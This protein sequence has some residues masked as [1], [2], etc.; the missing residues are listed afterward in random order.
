MQFF[1]DISN[2]SNVSDYL[3]ILN[4]CINTEI[5]SLLLLDFGIVQSR[6]LN[7]WY[8]KY[9]LIASLVDTLILFIIIIITR[10]LYKYLFTGF[11]I[12]NF[13]GLAIVVQ[14]IHD[15][16]FYTFV[17]KVRGKELNTF[18][19]YVKPSH[20]RILCGDAILISVV[21]LSSSYF[22]SLNTNANIINLIISL[23]ILPYFISRRN[24]QL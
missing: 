5:T 10:Y 3:P 23:Y 20:L 14:I 13:I 17:K 19:M 21:C 1:K 4:G 24:D 9:D 6:F 22:A 18:K 7:K 15:I 12:I 8:D 11:S 16:V 2:F